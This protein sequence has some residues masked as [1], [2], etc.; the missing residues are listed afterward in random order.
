M[1]MRTHTHRKENSEGGG[2]EQEKKGGEKGGEM[3]EGKEGK[4][5]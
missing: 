1:H 2:K 5:G 4:T 3:K